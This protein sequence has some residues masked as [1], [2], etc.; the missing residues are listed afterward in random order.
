MLKYITLIFLMLGLVG[1][2]CGQRR[3]DSVKVAIALEAKDKE[4]ELAKNFWSAYF[5]LPVQ[6]KMFGFKGNNPK[7]LYR[8]FDLQYNPDTEL[9]ETTVPWGFFELHVHDEGFKDI[10]FP[11]RIKGDLTEKFDLE[12][13]SLSYTYKNRKRYNYIAGTLR[14][15]ETILVGF[16]GDDYATNRA[17]LDQALAVEGLEHIHV[18][19]AYKMRGRNAFV[20]TLDIW[21]TRELPAILYQKIS[22]TP[23]IDRGIIIAN[24]VTKAIDA[25][26]KLD[27]VTFAN[28]TFLDDSEQTFRKSENYGKSERLEYKLQTY[29]EQDEETLR[30]INYII[31]KTTPEE[32]EEEEE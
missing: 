29:Q 25:Y 17:L 7:H 9:W 22:E 24:D 28:P 16:S 5:N 26:Q 10:V 15:N 11:L 23:E 1:T 8:T 30:K 27:Q 32:E 4:V 18:R 21:D 19:R 3:V 20:V 31:D 6:L 12:V 2:I 13:D 14:F